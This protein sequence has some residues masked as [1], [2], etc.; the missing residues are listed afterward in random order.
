MLAMR[1]EEIF[2][3]FLVFSVGLLVVW[4]VLRHN[5]R[6]NQLKTIQSVIE[7]GNI[8]A[9]TRTQLIEALSTDAR[10]R[11]QIWSWVWQQ[12]PRIARTV[13]VTVGWLTFVI[14][15]IVLIGMV[16]SDAYYYDII[17]ASVG[18]GVGFALLTLPMALREGEGR[19]A[20]MRSE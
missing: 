2:V 15:G 7:S 14:G 20:P 16:V 6:Q 4:L 10:R 11:N 17:G 18:T 5:L 1:D 13:C 3:L 12:G 9:T 19:R 8:D